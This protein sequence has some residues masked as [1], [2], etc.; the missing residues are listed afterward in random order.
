MLLEEAEEGAKE[1]L[2]LAA[3]VEIGLGMLDLDALLLEIEE[4]EL[5]DWV[6]GTLVDDFEV[7]EGAGS[8]EGPGVGRDADATEL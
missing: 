1:T 7:E 5:V 4:F 3:V 6:A 2:E 8:E